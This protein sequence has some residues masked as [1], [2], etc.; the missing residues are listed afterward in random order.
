MKHAF[1]YLHVVLLAW[2]AFG[3]KSVMA[4]ETDP[5]GLSLANTF[6]DD[7]DLGEYWVSEKLDGVR[8]FW[9]GETLVSRRGNPFVAP[10]WFVEGF[11]AAPLD[12]ELWMGPWH[13]RSP[14]GHCPP[15]RAG[16]R[17]VA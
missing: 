15:S 1:L 9:D 14:V 13:V 11:P 5:P 3:A 6:R 17:R 2:L 10:P 16:G 4:A 7:V 8:A 12:G